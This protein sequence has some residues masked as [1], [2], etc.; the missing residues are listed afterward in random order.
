MSKKLT[1]LI[2]VAIILI[3]AVL[4]GWKLHFSDNQQTTIVQTATTTTESDMLTDTQQNNESLTGTVTSTTNGQFIYRNDK[5]GIQFVFPA[6]WHIG[7]DSLNNGTLQLFNYDERMP[8]K[9]FSQGMNKIEA[10]I[11]THNVYFNTEYPEK[12]SSTKQ[13]TVAGQKSVQEDLELATGLKIR[14]YFIPMPSQP[15]LYFG[16]AVYGD[17]SN[18][19]VLDNLVQ[20]LSWVK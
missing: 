1:I 18:F 2:V 7:S 14:A 17:P 16:I 5:I 19:Y 12:A 13:I 9:G 4:A 20:S 10:D 6:G 15:D 8:R 3:A 11:N